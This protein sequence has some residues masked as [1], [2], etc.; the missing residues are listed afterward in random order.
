MSLVP[1]A[2]AAVL[3]ASEIWANLVKTDL[4]LPPSSMEMMRQWSS[5]FTQHSAVFDSLWKIP[6]SCVK[7]IEQ[8][9][10]NDGDP[11]A[12]G[13]HPDRSI[14]LVVRITTAGQ[15]WL[16]GTV[17]GTF[18]QAK[19]KSIPGGARFHATERPSRV[20][21]RSLVPFCAAMPRET[22]GEKYGSRPSFS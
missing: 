15:K 9:K 17:S 6:R 1:L 19:A 3:S 8:Y 18:R 20:P 7:K 5:S 16:A 22:M 12:N 4:T 11:R 13:I 21:W 14:R 2:S 10:L